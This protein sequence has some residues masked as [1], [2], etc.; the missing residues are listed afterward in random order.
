MI[1]V[2]IG[3]ENNDRNQFDFRVLKQS[4][5]S[6][7]PSAEFTVGTIKIHTIRIILAFFCK[8]S[9]IFVLYKKTITIILLT[10]QQRFV[11]D[12]GKHEE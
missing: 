7:G 5:S 2:I 1:K 11:Y 3:F 8:V 9:L 4:Q 12:S 6:S 10:L